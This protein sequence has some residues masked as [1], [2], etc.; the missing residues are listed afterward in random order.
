MPPRASEQSDGDYPRSDFFA[1]MVLADACADHD[2]PEQA[3]HAALTALSN[4]RAL[5]S[6]RCVAYVA[7]FRQRLD[8]FGDLPAVRDF[9]DQAAQFALWTKAA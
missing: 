4:G 5:G 8:R 1:E 7:E 6:A 2:D 3:C 9:R